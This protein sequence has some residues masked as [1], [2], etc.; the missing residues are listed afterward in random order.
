MGV[1]G[2]NGFP[3]CSK[4][5]VDII[6]TQSNLP[7]YLFESQL[8]Q[9]EDDMELSDV[10]FQLEAELLEHETSASKVDPDMD[11]DPELEADLEIKPEFTVLRPKPEP[12]LDTELELNSCDEAI[13]QQMYDLCNLRSNYSSHLGPM[14]EKQVSDN[15][16][17]IHVQTSKHLFWAE[18]HI[19]V[20]EHSIERAID[21][22]PSKTITAILTSSCM[23]QKSVAKDILCSKKQL[24]SSSTPGALSA[25]SSQTLLSSLSSS[26][27]PSAI[28]LADLINFA[29][30]LVMASSSKDLPNL[31]HLVKT[32]SQKAMELSTEPTK[33]PA[34]QPTREEL[35]LEKPP[36]VP[37][38][39][40]SE[41]PLEAGEPQ[42]VCKKE[43]M[44]FPG[45]CLGFT[46]P[47]VKRTTIEGEVKFLQP[48]ALAPQ[49]QGNRKDSVPGTKKGNPLLLKIHFKLS[50]PSSPQK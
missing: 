8:A 14:E 11:L 48:P 43:G 9:E 33:K 18:K 49:P 23:D 13:E 12:S 22:E 30:S 38:K 41:K 25:R 37:P 5:S 35:K 31:E 24:Q 40:P 44:T 32:S 27:L 6:D 34:D 36:E 16:R 42:K 28:G 7:Q 3:C 2:A 45:A 50:S 15:Y 19:Q 39:K 26:H 46:K 20:S 29:S 21:L 1:T 17:S 10:P 4:K 47:G